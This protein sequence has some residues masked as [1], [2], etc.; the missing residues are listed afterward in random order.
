M[1]WL[2]RPFLLDGL[3]LQGM[4]F[5]RWVFTAYKGPANSVGF[6]KLILYKSYKEPETDC[7]KKYNVCAYINIIHIIYIYIFVSIPFVV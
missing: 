1:P 2:K 4:C 6:L 5:L 7:I 3:L